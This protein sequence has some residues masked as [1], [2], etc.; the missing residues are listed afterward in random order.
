MIIPL[1]TFFWKLLSLKKKKKK[2]VITKDF[3]MGQNC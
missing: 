1:P 3:V 2:Q